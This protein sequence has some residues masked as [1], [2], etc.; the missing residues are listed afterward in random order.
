[1]SVLSVNI[2][3]QADGSVIVTLVGAADIPGA[4]V[5]ERQLL[6]VTVQHPK[7]VVLDLSGLTFLSSLSM[8]T[9][10]SFRRGCVGWG[11]KLT[12]AGANSMIQGS[13]RHA[14]LDRLLP[15]CESV[16]AALAMS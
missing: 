16:E 13:L 11:G 15:M 6:G 1:M 8:G 12:L 7:Q 2:T 10:M 3:T 5:L 4:A 9:I 14:G